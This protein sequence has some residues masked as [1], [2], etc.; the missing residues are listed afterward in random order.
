[1]TSDASIGLDDPRDNKQSGIDD[2]Q[3]AR[4]ARRDGESVQNDQPRPEL[5]REDI[6]AGNDGNTSADQGN[7]GGRTNKLADDGIELGKP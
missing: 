2:E 4:T 5:T 1:M 7:R 3:D 6:E